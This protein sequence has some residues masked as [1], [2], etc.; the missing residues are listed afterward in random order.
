VSLLEKKRRICASATDY[1]GLI[2]DEDTFGG[3]PVM[4]TSR[5]RKIALGCAEERGSLVTYKIPKTWLVEEE[6][7]P[8]VGNIGEEE[9]DF[10]H[11]IPPEFVDT[12]EMIHTD[13]AFAFPEAAHGSDEE[14]SNQHPSSDPNI[15]IIP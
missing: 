13:E 8:F 2:T 15:T 7:R 9:I 3:N 1:I 4:H 11:S 6:H 5:S 14:I 12:I 10:F